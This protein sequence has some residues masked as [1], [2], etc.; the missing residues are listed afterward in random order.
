MM[1]TVVG[2]GVSD[3]RG[4]QPGPTT[5]SEAFSC[6][7]PSTIM[8][9]ARQ[10]VKVNCLLFATPGCLLLTPLTALLGHWARSAYIAV[11]TTHMIK[12]KDAA[13]VE[14]GRKGGKASARKL[15][16]AQRTA[17]ARKAA[18]AKWAKKKARSV[19]NRLM[20]SA[21]FPPRRAR[22]LTKREREVAEHVAQGQSNK[23][24]ADR[25]RISVNTVKKHISRALE[26]LGA[27][28][29]TEL[30]LLLTIDRPG[31]EK[32]KFRLDQ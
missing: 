5:Q 30:A 24:I 15:T 10:M 1:P 21:G 29:R 32:R 7:R 25:L 19:V 16:A 27:S 4:P 22:R 11:I 6:P 20:P 23:Y 2:P 14:L 8:R 12:K 13:A 18:Q 17:K 31:H 9:S 26:K 3:W 28:N